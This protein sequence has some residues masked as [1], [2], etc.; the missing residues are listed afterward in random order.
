[1]AKSMLHPICIKKN[2]VRSNYYSDTYRDYF[3]LN[4]ITQDWDITLITLP[5]SAERENLLIAKYGLTKENLPAFYA[6][7]K[8]RLQRSIRIAQKLVNSEKP[9]ISEAAVRY[10]CIDTDKDDE[11][12]V[13]GIYLV[14]APMQKVTESQHFENGTLSLNSFASF[15]ARFSQIARAF[16]EENVHLGALDFDD[17]MFVESDGKLMV[18][19]SNFLYASDDTD[20]G[21]YGSLAT[22]PIY[23]DASVSGGAK[24]TLG[25]DMYAIAALLW[26]TAG[27]HYSNDSISFEEVPQ[28]VPDSLIA[29]LTEAMQMDEAKCRDFNREFHA[30]LRAIKNG[31][32]ENASIP[33][34][35]PTFKVQTTPVLTDKIAESATDCDAQYEEDVDDFSAVTRKKA[36]SNNVQASSP[37]PTDMIPQKKSAPEIS[38][39]ETRPQQPAYTEKHIQKSPS[40]NFEYAS[41]PE[42]DTGGGFG[43]TNR[44]FRRKTARERPE[45]GALITEAQIVKEID[46]MVLP[47]KQGKLK[48]EIQ[49]RKKN[50]DGFLVALTVILL[51][52]GMLYAYA[53]S[54]NTSLSANLTAAMLGKATAARTEVVAAQDEIINTVS[55]PFAGSGKNDGGN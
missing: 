47:Y 10:V 42:N 36:A 16:S 32:L 54:T 15:G 22:M 49:V 14:T 31:E 27:G 51:V 19:I 39:A 8:L 44:E 43:P 3:T 7:F 21:N 33:V 30:V 34:I 45:D 29:A 23:A 52:I 13:T 4:G 38:K 6:E 53:Q 17:V 50:G 37:S 24:A 41:A 26:Q 46:F 2:I 12:G 35:I 1:M 40:E 48:S 28:Y 20:D 9:G 25:T 18:T 11:T 5:F 55:A